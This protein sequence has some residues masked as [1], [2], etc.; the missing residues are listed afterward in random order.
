MRKVESWGPTTQKILVLLAGGIALGLTRSPRN[1][2]YILR[3]IPKE[4]ERIDRRAL[5]RAIRILYSHKL[6]A[7][8]DNANGTTTLFLTDKGKKKALAYH[9]DEITIPP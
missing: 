9:I 5:Q 1:Y 3:A 2:F 4:F 8:K 6:I 7:G